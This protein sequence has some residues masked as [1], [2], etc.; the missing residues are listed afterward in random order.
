MIS[1]GGFTSPITVADSRRS[2]KKTKKGRKN[3]MMTPKTVIRMMTS[4]SKIM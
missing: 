2:R 4:P 3:P 1:D